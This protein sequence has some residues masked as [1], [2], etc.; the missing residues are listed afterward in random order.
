MRIAIC[1]NFVSPYREPVFHAL[2]SRPG[3]DVTVFTCTPMEADRH[4]STDHGDT[5]F[6]IVQST[7]W[8]RT[9]TL[10]TGGDAGFDQKLIQHVPVGLAADILRTRPDVIISGELGPRTAIATGIGK[11][12]SSPVIPWTY[13]AE[14]Q[15]PSLQ[16]TRVWRRHLLAG[17]P[18]V[19]GMGTQA[20]RVLERM[21]CQPEKIFD[22]LNAADVSGVANRLRQPDHADSR[23]AIRTQTAQSRKLAIVVGRLIPMKGTDR[24]LD[25]WRALPAHIRD[26]WSLAFLGDGPL[27]T[28]VQQSGIDGVVGVGHVDGSVLADW[29]AAADLHIFP[30]LGDPWGLVVN[31]AM[32]VGTPTLCSTRAGCA[33]D[34]IDPGYNG[35]LFD[36]GAPTESLANDLTHALTRHDLNDLGAQAQRDIDAVTPESMAQGMARA[37]EYALTAQPE[38]T[39]A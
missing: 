25:A 3:W 2:A 14:A 26:Q 10:R 6:R 34:L 19:I 18:A 4:W 13:H 1:T 30:S 31:E 38:R 24:I 27:H 32:Q 8:A 15:T 21:G 28:L 16:K 5:R 37:I 7:S 29:Y 17:A 39:A 23:D 9:R 20:R 33:E 12:I 35:L 22:T 11:A 36:P